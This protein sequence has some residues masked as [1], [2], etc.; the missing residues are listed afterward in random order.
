M[1]G[2]RRVEFTLHWL[3]LQSGR[4]QFKHNRVYLIGVPLL[5]DMFL[6]C[7]KAVV[8]LVRGKYSLARNC[9]YVLVF[10]NDDITY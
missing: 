7:M 4:K 2:R 8:D 1:F 9:C 3:T 6:I 10:L 5:L